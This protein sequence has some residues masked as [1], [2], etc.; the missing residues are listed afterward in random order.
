MRLSRYLFAMS[1]SRLVASQEASAVAS[2]SPLNIKIIDCDDVPSRRAKRKERKIKVCCIP[3]YPVKVVPE[4]N[5]IARTNIFCMQ[6]K[7]SLHLTSSSV[8][9]SECA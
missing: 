1:V 5:D 4:F 9:N 8:S 7:F 2:D 3:A 6:C